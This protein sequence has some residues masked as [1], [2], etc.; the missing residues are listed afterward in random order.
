MSSGKGTGFAFISRSELEVCLSRDGRPPS[1]E[2][3]DRELDSVQIA[4]EGLFVLKP[5]LALL[6]PMQP[7][8]WTALQASRILGL[9]DHPPVF[10]SHLPHSSHS[11]VQGRMRRRRRSVGDFL[12]RQAVPD[13]DID[14]FP[15]DLPDL[16][17]FIDTP[18]LEVRASFHQVP[19]FAS[20]GIGLPVGEDPVR[21][22]RQRRITGW[23][24]VLPEPPPV[25]VRGSCGAPVP[26]NVKA[27][28]RGAVVSVGNVTGPG[29]GGGGGVFVEGGVIDSSPDEVIL[30]GIVLFA[31]ARARPGRPRWCWGPWWL[32][33]RPRRRKGSD[34]WGPLEALGKGSGR[35]CRRCF[36]DARPA[37]WTPKLG[38]SAFPPVGNSRVKP[39]P[40]PWRE[41]SV[42]RMKW[43]R[44]VRSRGL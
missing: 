31:V 14:P 9:Y 3:I 1:P 11:T 36:E 2:S 44:F 22:S 30:D 17:R 8:I 34:W 15:F 43:M 40:R 27:V 4:L 21:S 35:Q 7:R 5:R 16:L 24:V 41:W 10:K 26:R 20:L 42:P 33:R 19:K 23:N 25:D 32:R 28:V 29:S 6:G 18:M 37:S 38:L 12:Q 13:G 39:E